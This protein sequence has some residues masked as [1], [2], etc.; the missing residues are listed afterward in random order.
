MMTLKPSGII[1]K[2]S[3]ELEGCYELQPIVRVDLRGR[4]VKTFHCSEFE[5]LGLPIE[6]KEEYYSVSNK[7]VLRGLHFQLPPMDH[8]KLVYCVEGKVLDVA[9]D[10]RRDSATYGKYH[11][12]DLDSERGNMAYLPKGMAHG[13]YTLSE[14][15]LMMY[16]VTSEYAPE[17]DAGIRWDSVGIPWGVESPI[18]SER[19]KTF[20]PL[21]KFST[22][23]QGNR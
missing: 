15:A 9:V 7:G 11:L 23:F 21:A 19:D 8:E 20:P 14:T 5:A 6:F 13:F 22:P 17:S 16:K 10:L 2:I 12:F 4:F 3:T 1:Q 18:M